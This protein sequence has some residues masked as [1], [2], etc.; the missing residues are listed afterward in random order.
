MGQYC[1]CAGNK[2]QLIKGPPQYTGSAGPKEGPGGFIFPDVSPVPLLSPLLSQR[3]L[4]WHPGSSGYSRQDPLHKQPSFS[5]AGG[6]CGAAMDTLAPRVPIAGAHGGE[7]PAD[8][9]QAHFSEVRG[10]DV[11][12][13]YYVMS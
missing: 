13:G 5:A 6:F 1:G 11:L 7:E 4:H 2:V 9:E 3:A 8:L 10:R 12:L